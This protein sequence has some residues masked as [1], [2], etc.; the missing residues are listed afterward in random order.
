MS[1]PL[2]DPPHKKNIHTTLQSKQILHILK[3]LQTWKSLNTILPLQATV[4]NKLSKWSLSV[5]S[6]YGEHRENVR[7]SNIAEITKAPELCT[8]KRIKQYWHTVIGNQQDLFFII[9]K[10]LFPSPICVVPWIKYSARFKTWH[11]DNWALEEP[12]INQNG[13]K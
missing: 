12:Q 3:I 6:L 11:V 2:E 7:K 9:I 1:L 13:W 4:S 8:W 10:W 5:V